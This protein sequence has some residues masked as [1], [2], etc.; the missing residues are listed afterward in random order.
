MM[1]INFDPSGGPQQSLL[2]RIVGGVVGVI[3]L[4][5]A[6]MFSAVVFVAVA[7]VAL[8]LWGWFWWKTRALRRQMQEQMRQPMDGAR[9]D[10]PFR[11]SSEAPSGAPA[12]ASNVIDGESVRVDDERDRIDQ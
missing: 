6:F 11:A 7:V 4:I 8:A 12:D 5:G 9:H 3:V 2:A 10:S 1:Y